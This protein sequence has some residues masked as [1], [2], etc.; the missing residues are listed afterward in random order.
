MHIGLEMQRVFRKKKHGM[1]MVALHLVRELVNNY[2]ST[3]FTVFA[4]PDEDMQCLSAG[5]NLNINAFKGSVYPIWEQFYLPKQVHKSRVDLLHCTA[6]TAPLNV[7]VPLVI[8]LHDIIYL[9][10]NWSEI[11]GVPYQRFGNYY[12]KLVVPSNVRQSNLL[13]TVSHFEKGRIMEFLGLPEEKVRVVYNAASSHFKVISDR[14][15]LE[16][17]RKEFGLPEQFIL[18]LG[19]TDPKKN[20][21]NTLHAYLLLCL[22]QKQTPDLVIADLDKV[23]L[24]QIYKELNMPEWV[25]QKIKTMGYV[26]NSRLPEIF[27]LAEFYLYTS[28]RES[29]G[30]PLLEAMACGCPVIT[31]NTSSMPE[32]AENAA[33]LTDPNKPD[34]IAAAMLTLLNSDELKKSLSEKGLSRAQMFSWKNAATQMHE[35]YQE[36]SQNNNN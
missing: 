3:N 1:D 10:K 13:V 29:F 22:E 11:K 7:K 36:L 12:R 24:K 35:I 16:S 2:P 34:E 30:I 31:S 17:S 15:Q 25:Q 19:N 23:Y 18:F 6:N 20:T 21:P 26:P 8:T 14:A 28:L 33:L 32:V 5:K 9:E 27:N 4:T